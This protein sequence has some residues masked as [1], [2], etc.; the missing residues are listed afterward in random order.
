MTMSLRRLICLC[1]AF[2]APKR[3]VTSFLSHP[4]S[5]QQEGKWR[6]VDECSFSMAAT[7]RIAGTEELTPQKYLS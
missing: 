6:C 2:I 1:F 3:N 4:A 5:C 7:S